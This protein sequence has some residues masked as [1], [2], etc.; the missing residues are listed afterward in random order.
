MIFYE[1]E[2]LS[3]PEI[4]FS[5]KVDI[6]NFKNRFFN[7]T[8]FLEIGL[9]EEGAIVYAYENGK[10]EIIYP[11]MIN[12]IFKDAAFSSYA[13]NGERQKHTTVGV[14]VK[15]NFKRYESEKECNITELKKRMREKNI[16]LIPNN[17]YAKE[18]YEEIL[19]ILD[20]INVLKF[21]ETG[22]SRI[23]MLSLWYS[24]TGLLT[25]FI[26]KKL[27][28][29]ASKL[30]PS[31]TIY[32]NKATQYIN[33]NLSKKLTVKEIA[34]FLK[35]SEGYLHKIFKDMKGMGVLEYANINRVLLAIELTE[36][37][38][39][40]LKEAASNIGINDPAYMSRL[41]KKVTGL[42]F[43]EY[44]RKNTISR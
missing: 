37:L 4:I 13:L 40:S 14:L 8:D 38:N 26:L 32:F 28:N 1:I 42:S 25:D 5:C 6:K 10:T 27:E 2:L 41:F 3:V 21:S 24:L 29:A 20:K 18:K 17:I 9:I 7:M 19:K 34:D 35:I 12:S 23:K 11:K 30:P 33:Q 43:R 31:E 15:Y 36:N 22:S 44:S 16:I 39:L